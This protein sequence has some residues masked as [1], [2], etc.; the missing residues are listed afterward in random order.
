MSTPGVVAPTQ[1]RSV[2]P[3]ATSTGLASRGSD[4]TPPVP[5]RAMTPP[6]RWNLPANGCINAK[7]LVGEF[8]SQFTK[9]ADVAFDEFCKK[10]LNSKNGFF[11][12]ETHFG[13]ASSTIS[14]PPLLSTPLKN[15]QPIKPI[16][17]QQGCSINKSVITATSQVKSQL[18]PKKPLE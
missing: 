13:Q 6:P 9:N 3:P 11:T 7:T 2:T 1:T 16:I 12:L 14:S 15:T 10:Y 8:R 4:E 17:Q 18:S 5:N